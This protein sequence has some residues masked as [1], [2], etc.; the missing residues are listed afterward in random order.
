MRDD[1]RL[2]VAELAQR[3]D[4]AGNGHGVFVVS[5]CGGDGYYS[6]QPVSAAPALNRYA[7]GARTI[8]SVNLGGVAEPAQALAAQYAWNASAPG[9][10]AIAR[11]REAALAQLQEAR[12]GGLSPDGAML[13]DACRLLYG[14][15]A[16]P[17]LAEALEGDGRHWPVVAIWPSFSRE[18][19]ALTR[20]PEADREERSEHWSMRGR[21]TEKA[22]DLVRRA[23]ECASLRD[24]FREDLAWLTER[25]RLGVEFCALMSDTWDAIARAT[26]LSGNAWVALAARLREE[27]P[28]QMHDPIGGDV[29][30]AIEIAEAMAA[31]C[32]SRASQQ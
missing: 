16:G 10:V 11:S 17:L 9:S 7:L 22:V 18:V 30:A 14:P 19:G 3:L 29:A 2:R 31:F 5:F 25:M 27:A 24:R 13:A 23:L 15:C 21:V 26:P 4:T 12:S 1:G 32:H 28:C 6:D 8:Y 20:T